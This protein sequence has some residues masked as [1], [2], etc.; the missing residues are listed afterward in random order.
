MIASTLLYAS[1]IWGL[2]Y[3][4]HLETT[5]T[6]FIRRLLGLGNFTANYLIRLE[7]GRPRLAV[8]VIAAAIRLWTKIL[9]MDDSRLPRQCYDVLREMDRTS[10]SSQY[11]WV[12]QFRSLL[13]VNGLSHIWNSHSP[14]TTIQHAEQIFSTLEQMSFERDVISVEASDRNVFYHCAIR[15]DVTQLPEYLTSKLSLKDKRTLAEMR[16]QSE[17]LLIDRSFILLQEE[18]TCPV[19]NLS[20]P[21][22]NYHILAECPHSRTQFFMPPNYTE[23]EMRQGRLL[24][25]LDNIPSDTLTQASMAIR[26]S[27]RRRQFAQEAQL[28]DTDSR[29]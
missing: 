16:L 14:S 5:Q 6:K 15:A 11:N 19:C 28:E 9:D 22:D 21:N 18:G 20:K 26:T 12:T 10:P 24:T 17:F 8:K 29:V 13:E 23:G 1:E 7:A 2:R 4:E 27:L 25:F 3:L